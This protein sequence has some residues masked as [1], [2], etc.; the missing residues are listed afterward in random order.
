MTK[1]LIFNANVLLSNFK[2]DDSLPAT[3]FDFGQFQS[4][5]RIVKMIKLQF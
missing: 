4:P 2:C 1:L 3:I 5:S